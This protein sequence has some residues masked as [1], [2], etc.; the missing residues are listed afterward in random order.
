M[1]QTQR[2]NYDHIAPHYDTQSYRQKTVDAHL[3]AYLDTHPNPASITILDISCGT[4]NQLAAN[5]EG[6]SSIRIVGL[7]RFH[8]MLRQAQPKCQDILW[9]Q[10][11]GAYPPFPDASFD[12]ITNQTAFH[13]IPQQ[14]T[15]LQAVWRLLRP[16]GQFVMT[17]ICP[18]EMPN[19]LYYRYF[20][21]T[22]ELD[23]KHFM[24]RQDIVQHLRTIGFT[25][26]HLTL[27]YTTNPRDLRGFLTDV[28]QRENASQLFAIPEHEYHAGIH[29]IK[30]ELAQ[31]N[32]HTVMVQSEFCKLTLIAKKQ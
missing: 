29:K 18:R 11:D 16:G 31:A 20:S 19:G 28:C 21:S 26:I 9:I 15:M 23:L 6:I 10:A 17:N 22:W 1:P 27:D 32:T 14:V 3:L 12:Y 7:D 13:H 2:I 30:T 24:P 4:G 8:G 5:R 25:D